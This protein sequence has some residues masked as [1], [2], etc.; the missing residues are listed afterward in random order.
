[1][2]WRVQRS[3]HDIETEGK[4]SASGFDAD[5]RCLGRWALTRRL[6]SEEDTAVQKRGQRIH[7]ALADFT[8]DALSDTDARTAS[9]IAYLEAQIVHDFGFEGAEV[10]FEQRF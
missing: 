9:R 10:N 8:F 3:T 1:M 2:K 6:P 5:F 4:P 7:E